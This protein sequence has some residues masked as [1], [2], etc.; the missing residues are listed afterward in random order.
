MNTIRHLLLTPLLAGALWAEDAAPALEVNP[1]VPAPEAQPAVK[2]AAIPAA[3]PEVIPAAK[4]AEAKP[5]VPERTYGNGKVS[6]ARLNVR[7]RPGTIYEAVAIL[8]QDDPIRIVSESN[9]WVE[10]AVPATA[11]AW[12][13][14]DQVDKDG[15]VLD[16]EI[17]VRCGAGTVYNPYNG[18]LRKGDQVK[19]LG[20]EKDGWLKI[21]PAA[22]K[23]G[24]W[25][26][27][28]YITI[29][30]PAKIAEVVKPEP[31]PEPPKPEIKPVEPPKPEIKPIPPKPADPVDPV[32][33]IQP[34]TG[35]TILL[36]YL[37]PLAR[38]NANGATHQVVNTRADGTLETVGLVASKHAYINLAEWEK[39][40]VRV[41]GREI[42]VA[43]QKDPL[44]QAEGIQIESK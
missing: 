17:R 8:R 27:R 24:A 14:R 11:A 32:R 15:I 12:I 39:W 6:A 36:G 5:A 9:D 35:R 23:L 4:P 34:G 2:P 13:H 37:L 1:A 26:G 40:R 25:V 43:G 18:T 20:E 28:A 38:P 29:E 22:D 21:V 3:Q 10:I 42:K 44:L 30:Q 7:V 41:Y 33:S 31:K 16:E 19:L